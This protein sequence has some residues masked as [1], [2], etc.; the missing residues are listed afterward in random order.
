MF[1]VGKYCMSVHFACFLLQF[2][3]SCTVLDVKEQYNTIAGAGGET[4]CLPPQQAHEALDIMGTFNAT[5]HL[6]L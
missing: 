1:C 6:K 2:C 3:K 4:L 5:C